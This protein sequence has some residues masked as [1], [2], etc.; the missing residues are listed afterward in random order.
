MAG[1]GERNILHNCKGPHKLPPKF[2]IPH[3]FKVILTHVKSALLFRDLNAVCE[4]WGSDSVVAED[5]SLLGCDG[6]LVG[7]RFP[8]FR[9]ILS[10]SSSFVIIPWW[11]DCRASLHWVTFHKVET[12][13]ATFFEELILTHLVLPYAVLLD[14]HTKGTSKHRV[15]LNYMQCRQVFCSASRLK[16]YAA[17][18]LVKGNRKH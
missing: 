16:T 3:L 18:P 7:E 6:V 14:I 1:N 17:L 12:L 4:M 9:Y 13:N 8:M 5:W 10:R 11:M 15:V 2:L